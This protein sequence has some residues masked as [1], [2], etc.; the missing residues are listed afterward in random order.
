[1][2]G[3]DNTI[4]KEK[5]RKE[6]YRRIW[7]MLGTEVNAKNE[8]IVINTLTISVITYSFN[9]INRALAETKKDGYES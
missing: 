5:I 9:M 8:V 2:N 7:V 3:I 6:F 1:M 4:N